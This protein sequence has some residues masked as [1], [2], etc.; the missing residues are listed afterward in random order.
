MQVMMG[1]TGKLNESMMGTTTPA[2]FSSLRVALIS[3]TPLHPWYVIY[4]FNLGVNSF[5]GFNL[6]FPTPYFMMPLFSEAEDPM[7][8]LQSLT[9]GLTKHANAKLEISGTR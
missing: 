9:K 3:S 5:R 8:Q 4:F 7:W 1:Q 2:S 6:T